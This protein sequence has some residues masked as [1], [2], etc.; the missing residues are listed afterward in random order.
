MRLGGGEPDGEHGVSVVGAKADSQCSVSGLR[1]MM[2]HSVLQHQLG[3]KQ[4]VVLKRSF[5]HFH[6]KVVAGDSAGDG[7]ALGQVFVPI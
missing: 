1:C 4:P 5:G 3:V 6:Y 7:F 2:M